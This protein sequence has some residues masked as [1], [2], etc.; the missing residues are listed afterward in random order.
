MNEQVQEFSSDMIEQTRSCLELEVVLN[1]DKEGPVYEP[2][3]HMHLTSL[4]DAVD[5]YQKNVSLIGKIDKKSWSA[6]ISVKLLKKEKGQHFDK[7][8]AAAIGWHKSL[9]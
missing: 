9:K 7:W 3:Q 8:T 4:R 1:Y 5:K 6:A 2:G